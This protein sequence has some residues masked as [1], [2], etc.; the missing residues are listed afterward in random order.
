MIEFSREELKA[1]YSTSRWRTRIGK[2]LKV[3]W[4]GREDSNLRTPHIEYYITA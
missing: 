2:V 1:V 3:L 4:L